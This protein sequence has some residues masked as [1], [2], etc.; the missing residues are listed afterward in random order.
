MSRRGIRGVDEGWRGGEGWTGGIGEGA[1]TGGWVDK[2]IV[3]AGLGATFSGAAFAEFDALPIFVAAC[4]L[5]NNFLSRYL[6]IHYLT[7][8]P[9]QQN[10]LGES[11]VAH[12]GINQ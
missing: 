3:G 2:G 7:V 12:K 11:H 4:Q 8:M 9:H 6:Y 10:V 1:A 5:Q